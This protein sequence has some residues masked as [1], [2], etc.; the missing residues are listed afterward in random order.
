MRRLTALPAAVMV[1]V[2]GCTA[3]G[4]PPAPPA[5]PIPSA[6]PSAGLSRT[7]P[8][9]RGDKFTMTMTP[10]VRNGDVVVLTVP[11]RLDAAFG[12]N[13]TDVITST[14][15][16]TLTASFDGPRLIDEANGRVYE[17]AVN[18]TT[19]TC[20][21]AVNVKV[22]ETVPMQAAYTGVPDGVTRLTVQIPNAGVFYDVPVQE[23]AVPT[24]PPATHGGTTLAPLDIAQP[25]T[26]VA[27]D[28]TALTD[29]P[30]AGIVRTQTPQQVDINL[31]ADVLFQVDKS[32]LTAA[33]SR[34]IAAAVQDLR[35]SAPG[36]LTITGHT[37]NT[38]TAAHNQPL[39]EARA[40]TVANALQAA[41]PDAEWPTTVSGKGET[42]PI[43][44]NQTVAGR[45][46]NRRVTISYRATAPV[47][48]GSSGP[49][50]V[51]PATMPATT[52][53]IGTATTGVQV[54]VPDPVRFTAGPAVRRGE[55]VVVTLVAHND[56]TAPV[57][58]RGYLS[59]GFWRRKGT[60]LG[61]NQYDDS[62][63][64]L[65]GGSG[66]VS[67]PLDY[68]IEDYVHSCLCDPDLADSIAPG[69]LRE[70]PI[71][72]PYPGTGTTVDV[73]DKFRLTDVEIS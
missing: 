43:A 30:D 23:G 63:V 19:C 56:S 69:Q 29:E 28:L 54:A 65:L 44:S 62:G 57:S 32:T 20:T 55:Y 17:P 52:G 47:T 73:P 8:A 34:S 18:D 16:R 15:S 22:G 3:Q 38:G 41:L 14:F 51:V 46:L 9:D 5:S 49:N 53:V 1:L 11:T 27:R 37:D 61:Y 66:T 6:S 33:A 13:A 4:A 67:Y 36:P 72:F 7:F 68:Q 70:L 26:S 25:G 42:Q 24:P 35:R 45:Q 39:S 12:G 2:A 31:A 48:P 58:L 71:W 10:L 21:G 50:I 40:R 60:N 59:D 64:R